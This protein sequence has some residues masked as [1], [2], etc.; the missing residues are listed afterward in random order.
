[1][2]GKQI[3]LGKECFVLSGGAVDWATLGV[4]SFFLMPPRAPLGPYN[5]GTCGS[6]PEKRALDGKGGP[7]QS[8][9]TWKTMGLR[10]L[11]RFNH[12][13]FLQRGG[14]VASLLGPAVPIKTIKLFFGRRSAKE[15][16]LTAPA[17]PKSH[18]CRPISPPGIV[19]W[20][21]LVIGKPK[22]FPRPTALSNLLRQVLARKRQKA[23]Q[24]K[25]DL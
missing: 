15:A 5:W 8:P 9:I 12:F 25:F 1:L 24:K 18:G 13:F 2:S 19:E 3:A 14:R 22:V 10:G 6:F 11:F 16:L 21:F 4:F 20:F 23:L 7:S 17:I